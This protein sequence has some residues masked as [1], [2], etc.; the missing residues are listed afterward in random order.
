M[1]FEDGAGDDVAGGVMAEPR[2]DGN[3]VRVVLQ[4]ER[5][6]DL[7]V[8]ECGLGRALLWLAADQRDRSV[9]QRWMMLRGLMRCRS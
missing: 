4:R 7:G 5:E 2:G 1:G 6:A 3:E 9:L 8:A